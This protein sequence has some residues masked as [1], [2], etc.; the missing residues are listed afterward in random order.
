MSCN[1]FTGKN[2]QI[3]IKE[4]GMKIMGISA[5]HPLT[6]AKIDN[7]CKGH[8]CSHLCLPK[9]KSTLAKARITCACPAE[10]Q[11]LSDGRTCKSNITNSL[12][13]FVESDIYSLNPHKLTRSSFEL[14]GKANGLIGSLA[15]NVRTGDI[16]ASS[17]DEHLIYK[18]DIKTKGRTKI[19]ISS[20]ILHLQFDSLNEN[21]YW[22]DPQRKSI[23]AQSLNTNSTKAVIEHLANPRALVFCNKRQELL[24][25]DESKLVSSSPSGKKSFV[26]SDNIPKTVHL[27]F[28]HEPNDTLILGDNAGKTVHLFN[29]GTRSLSLFLSGITSLVSMAVFDG[30]FYWTQLTGYDLFW[31]KFD[32]YAKLI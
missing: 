31:V 21:L 30:Y 28:Y 27:L 9:P 18:I 4:T 7:P 11:L 19:P 15:N 20:N 2:K 26:L 5:Y 25:L 3:I 16:F 22:I 24:F 8:Q 32:R 29:L 10:M 6:E 1:K 12:L 17:M 13:V 14:M 23:M